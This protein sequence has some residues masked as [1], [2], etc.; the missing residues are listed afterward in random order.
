ML[1]GEAGAGQQASQ[2]L[3]RREVAVH[4]R[5]SQPAQLVGLVDELRA[6]LAGQGVQC[7]D[8]VAGRYVDRPR[9]RRLRRGD[10]RCRASKDQQ[11]T[12]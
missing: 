2:R 5:G 7:C 1:H 12:A 9:R 11:R 4:P 3:V 6:G 8:Q 10:G